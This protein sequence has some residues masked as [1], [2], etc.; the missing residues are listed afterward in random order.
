MTAVP[1]KAQ[2]KK[3][4]KQSE[5]WR[6]LKK[7]KLAVLGLIVLTFFVAVAIFADLIADYDTEALAMS[8]DRL[9]GPSKDHWFGTDHL[10]RDVFARVV[11]GTRLSLLIGLS[12][13]FIS[14]VVGG[15][16]GAAA[17]Y[18]GGKIDNIIMRIMDII[19]CIP[20][21]L[22]C[23][24]I[25]A[26]LGTNLVNLLAAI[27]FSQ[28]TSFARVVRSVILTIAGQDFV[29]AARA[30][31]MADLR[32][33]LQHII[34]NAIG[35]IIVQATMSVA[36]IIILTAGLSFLGMGVQPPSPEWGAMV[37]EANDHMRNDPHLMIA[38]GLAIVLTS[39]SLNLLGDGLRDAL[40]PRLK[41]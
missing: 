21:L 38:P 26:A 30:S 9:E 14:M 15:F 2:I 33:I 1:K 28:I 3:R 6:R 18:F 4:G 10:G 16:L 32:I 13:T 12:V 34:P 5:I 40:D 27:S 31:G 36:N 7:N 17:G 35:P 25:I 29:E 19:T 22:L 23:L 11:H 37:S 39:L 8:R 24:A 41:S 20:S